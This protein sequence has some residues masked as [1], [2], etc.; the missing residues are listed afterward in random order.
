MGCLQPI[1]NKQGK[2]FFL[3]KEAKTFFQLALTQAMRISRRAHK[4]SVMRRPRVNPDQFP[5]QS[6]SMAAYP[7]P[8]H[9]PIAT[10]LPFCQPQRSRYA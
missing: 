5:L 9:R 3:K 8:C 6:R 1:M 7:L 4:R 2:R 10:N